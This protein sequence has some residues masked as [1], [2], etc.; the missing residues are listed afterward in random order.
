MKVFVSVGT[1]PQPF[2]RLLRELDS[3]AARKKNFSFFAQT[4]SSSYKP[5]NFPSKPFLGE[6]EYKRRIREASL[7]ISHAGAGTIIN[8]MLQ[9]KRLIVVPRLLRFAEH[10]D[11]HQVDLAEALDA[12]GKVIAVKEMGQLAA[13]IERA[14]KF[15]PSAASGRERLVARIMGFLNEAGALRK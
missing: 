15:K 2:D 12:Q 4:G 9:R 11:D 7:V 5:K 8:S 1:H 3:I 6:Q 10:T 13:A 14:A